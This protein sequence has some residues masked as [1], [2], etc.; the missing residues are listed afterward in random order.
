MGAREHVGV[1]AGVGAP[2]QRL[3]AC[4]S[5]LWADSQSSLW[6]DL[7]AAPSP[8]PKSHSTCSGFFVVGVLINFILINSVISSCLQNLHRALLCDGSAER[9]CRQTHDSFLCWRYIYLMTGRGWAGERS[10]K[11]ACLLAFNVISQMPSACLGQGLLTVIEG[12]TP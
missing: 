8:S 6:C 3:S 11:A 1:L 9:G 4:P 7:S 12:Q 10:R 5:G 2:A